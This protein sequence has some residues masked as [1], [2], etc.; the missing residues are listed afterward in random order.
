MRA[1]RETLRQ[2]H[3]LGMHDVC[4][5]QFY[6]AK[7]ASKADRAIPASEANILWLTTFTGRVHFCHTDTCGHHVRGEVGATPIC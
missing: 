6:G 5:A 7:K 3:A 2:A 1:D 4:V